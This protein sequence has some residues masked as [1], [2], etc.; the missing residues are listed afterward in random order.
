MVENGWAIAFRKYSLEYVKAEES[1][2][3]KKAGI[4]AGTFVPPEEWRRSTSRGK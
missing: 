2:R 1:A 4:W 3:A